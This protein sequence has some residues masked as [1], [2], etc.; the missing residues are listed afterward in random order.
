MTTF[1]ARLKSNIIIIVERHVFLLKEIV[2]FYIC[3]LTL[4]VLLLVVH[5]C[6]IDLSIA[7]ILILYI[8]TG[9]KQIESF[10]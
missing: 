9:G 8:F 5:S 7:A 4:W 2:S 1:P 3:L 10:R 6:C